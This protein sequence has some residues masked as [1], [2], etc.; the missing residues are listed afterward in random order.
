MN[1][2]RFYHKQH[3]APLSGWGQ[4]SNR[5]WRDETDP[6]TRHTASAHRGVVDPECPACIEIQARHGKGKTTK[7]T[8]DTGTRI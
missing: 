8:D 3:N 5:A 6:L 1:G 4:F 2:G 7:G